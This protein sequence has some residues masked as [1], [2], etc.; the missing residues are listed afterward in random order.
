MKNIYQ[1]LFEVQKEIKPIVKDSTNPYF[2]S[3]YFDINKIIETVKP[4]L[5]KA[6]LVVLQPI[7]VQDNRTAL[8]TVVVDVDSGEQVESVCYL[9]DNVKP[10]E[11]GSAITYFRRYALQSLLFLQAEDDDGNVSS[12]AQPKDFAPRKVAPATKVV[13]NPH[14]DL[15]F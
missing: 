5:N 13:Q 3:Q 14:N 7:I 10:Q 9:P 15:P 11:M 2:N 4:I 8:K 6:N 12:N 1:K